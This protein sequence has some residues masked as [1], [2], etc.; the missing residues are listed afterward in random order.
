MGR[1]QAFFY[2]QNMKD[3][4][5]VS[6]ITPNWNCEEYIAK[7]IESVQAQTYQNWEMLI[8]D[9]CSTDGSL[10]VAYL[11]AMKDP[12]VKIEVN[13][14]N[15]GAAV[16]RNNAIKRS[17]GVY[18]AYLDSDDIWA[19]EK[20]ER[21]LSFMEEQQCDACFSRY[22]HMDTDGV[23]LGV[24]AQVKKKVTYRDLLIH[25]WFGCL[26]LIYK[27]DLKN[28]VYGIDLPKSN[29]YA[30][31]LNVMRNHKLA[32]GLDECLAAYRI[33]KGS[34]SR[35]KLKKVKWH[36]NVIRMVGHHSI[37]TAYCCLFTHMF[38]KTFF[39]YRKIKPQE[40]M[41]K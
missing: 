2:L 1:L 11:Y 41:L 12:R 25:D 29:D 21:Q 13:S 34:V 35:N 28:K 20:L 9:D 4:G 6:I 37:I 8:Q 32:C 30:L 23:S 17:R 36:T 16:T 24:Q 18:L 39:K 22:E 3:Y 33:R 27:Q 38:V 19:P 5:L 40:S 10:Q 7:T 14:K 26:T 31:F 15:S